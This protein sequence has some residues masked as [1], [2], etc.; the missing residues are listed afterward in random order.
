MANF[1]AIPLIIDAGK[2]LVLE[3]ETGDIETC[4]DCFLDLIVFTP[5]G[6]FSADPEFGFEYWNHEFANID[7]REFNN[8]YMGMVTN[9][10]ELN[11]ISRKQCEIS[12]R[13]SILAYE[14]RLLRP[15]V[16]IELEVNEKLSRRKSQSKYEMKILVSGAIDDGLGVTRQYEK[17][18]AFMV[19]PVAKKVN[20]I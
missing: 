18:I 13:D 6:S 12:L 9:V 16:K 3:Q 2:S 19:E 10:K 20:R 14:P 5:K 1:T 4:I 15:E 17:R 11:D 7:V 8:S